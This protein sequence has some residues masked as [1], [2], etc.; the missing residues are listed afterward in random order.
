MI[1]TAHHWHLCLAKVDPAIHQS[2]NLFPKFKVKLTKS[3]ISSFHFDLF[4]GQN[5]CVLRRQVPLKSV[6]LYVK[7]RGRLVTSGGDIGCDENFLFAVPETFDD[8]G[9]LFYSQLSCQQRH[10]VRVLCHLLCQP[11][12][13]FTF[14][15]RQI[16]M[17][18]NRNAPML[19]PIVTGKILDNTGLHEAKAECSQ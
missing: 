18:F 15:Q 3:F 4:V 14:L 13:C 12:C 9:T 16:N 11:W 2:R 17:H 1:A 8:G 7:K 6:S 5:N 10:S 19:K